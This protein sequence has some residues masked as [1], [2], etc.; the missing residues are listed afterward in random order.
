MDSAGKRSVIRFLLPVVFE[1]IGSTLIGMVF[2]SIIGGISKSALSAISTVNIVVNFYTAAFSLLSVGAAVLTARMFGA[3]E[4][5]EASRTIEQSLLLTLI[6]SLTLT[7][8]SLALAYPLMKLIMPAV[9]AQLLDEA[10]TYFRVNS[11][12]LPFLFLYTM[13][14]T[15]LR[16]SGNSRAPFFITMLQ[17]V[18]QVLVACL[19]ISVIHLEVVGAGL[20]MI[21]SRLAG[22]VLAL[23]VVLRTHTAFFVQP[24]NIFKP[25]RAIIKR[26][27]RLGI[28]ASF[29][30]CFVQ[31]GYLLANS[32][33]MGLGTDQ[34]AVYSLTNTLQSFANTPQGINSVLCTSFVGQY[35]GAKDYRSAKR[36]G[37]RA[38]LVGMPINLA[39]YLATCL[40]SPMLAPLYTTDAAVVSSTVTC[41]WIHMF[42]F[43]PALSI[44][45]IDPSLRAGGDV[46]FA[47]AETIVGVWLVRLPLSWLLAYHFDL[48]VYGIYIA[49]IVSLYVRAGCGLFRHISGKWMYRRV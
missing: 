34:A 15:V 25:D 46:K 11:I 37:Y 1:T 41:M 7:V 45:T 16:A 38:L 47:L 31:F 30:S 43:A 44:N 5:V 17:S 39:L 42:Y 48:G 29:E 22:A 6:F 26:L 3:H 28:P 14:I 9:E 21:V 27:I 49:N 12:S 40:L 32:L 20:A 24:R 10:V 2:S 23:A 18:V 8:L 35:I 33:T 36:F 19:F 13:L 4:K